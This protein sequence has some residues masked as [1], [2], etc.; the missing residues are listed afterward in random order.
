[1]IEWKSFS[2][3]N[4]FEPGHYL[5]TDGTSV[6]IAELDVFGANEDEWFLKERTRIDGIEA[7]THYAKVNLPE[8]ETDAMEKIAIGMTIQFDYVNWRGEQATR[9]AEVKGIQYG[10]TE[11]HPETQWLMSAWDIEKQANRVF[12]MNDMKNIVV[13]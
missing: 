10:A 1:M 5:V 2:L 4:P 3:R 7:V 6:E 8:N 13:L 12:A 11:Y 9:R